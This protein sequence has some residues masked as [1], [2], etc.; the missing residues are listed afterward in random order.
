MNFRKT[1]CMLFRT[2][3]SAVKCTQEKLRTYLATSKVCAFTTFSDVSLCTILVF[4]G[5]WLASISLVRV[6]VVVKHTFLMVSLSWQGIGLLP[7]C[8]GSHWWLFRVPSLLGVTKWSAVWRWCGS[9]RLLILRQ[10]KLE[11]ESMVVRWQRVQVLT[12]GQGWVA[13][14]SGREWSKRL[15]DGFGLE[16]QWCR[17][18]VMIKANLPIYRLILH[19]YPHL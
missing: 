17:H 2:Y 4:V 5:L 14:L 15:T 6:T 13:A 12:L 11:S 9:V 10:Q 8:L 7:V 1:S 16:L 18:P 3:F 19:P